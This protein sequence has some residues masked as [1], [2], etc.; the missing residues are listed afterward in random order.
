MLVCSQI[1]VNTTVNGTSVPGAASAS[2]GSKPVAGIGGAGGTT[3]KEPPKV[4]GGKIAGPSRKKQ[5]QEED[6]WREPN[7]FG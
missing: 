7:M 4:A 2:A 1:I 5:K 3:G 6:H